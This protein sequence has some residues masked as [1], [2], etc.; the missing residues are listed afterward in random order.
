MWLY[1]V[2][3]K[4]RNSSEGMFFDATGSLDDAVR[5]A[6]V[7]QRREPTYKVTVEAEDWPSL[8]WWS[9]Q[10]HRIVG[11]HD[12]FGVNFKNKHGLEIRN[13]KVVWPEVK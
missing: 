6:K 10:F 9:Y 3:A 12:G 13:I 5:M 4:S 7:I 2:M 1:R 11:T 8:S